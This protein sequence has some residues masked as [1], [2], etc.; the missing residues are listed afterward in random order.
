MTPHPSQENLRAIEQPLHIQLLFMAVVSLV[1]GA[2]IGGPK[3]G[4]A[5]ALGVLTAMGYYKLLAAQVRRQ[6]AFRRVPPLMLIIGALAGR[7]L[8]CLAVPAACFFTLG[9]AWLACLV[10]L[11]VA[12]HWIMI[13][14]WRG[15]RAA[16]LAP[17]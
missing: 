16:Q 10:T 13:V 15:N 5:A 4:L 9:T 17:T 11:V 3:V 2:V 14:A 6:F 7:Q 1:T 8:L 12:R